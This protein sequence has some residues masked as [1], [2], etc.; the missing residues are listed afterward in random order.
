M[1]I[2]QRRGVVVAP[3]PTRRKRT[4]LVRT[5]EEKIRQRRSQMLIHSYLY[6][7][8][9]SPVV[10]DDKWQQWADDLAEL[11]ERKTKIGFYDKVFADWDG[12]TGM[13]LPRD[14]FVQRKA[15]MLLET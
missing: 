7:W 1:A 4:G 8:L 15:K 12:S 3:A 2:R 5:L 11:Q 6:Y 10:S 14:E 9:D 13:H